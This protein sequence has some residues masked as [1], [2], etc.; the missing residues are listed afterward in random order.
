MS[1]KILDTHIHIWD[2]DKADYPWLANDSSL[3]HQTYRIETLEQERVAAGVTAGILVQAAGN[4][5]DTDLMLETAARKDWI[6]AVVAWLP[7]LDPLRAERVWK[8]KYSKNPYFKGVRHQIHDEP[9]PTWLLQ[10]P[11]IESLQ[12]LA[13][14]QLPYDL[15]GIRTEHIETAMG[16][17]T[18]V[19][20]LNMVFDHLNQPP[21]RTK[22]QFGR[23]GDLMK[24][25]AKHPGFY[26]KISGLGTTAGKDNW[27]EESLLPYLAFVLEH[28]GVDRC[29]CGGDWPVSLLA[30]S[31]TSTWEIYRKA[32]AQLVPDADAE[33]IL[34]SNA[35]RFYNLPL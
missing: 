12:W 18:K 24:E 7:L 19:P 23:W 35:C 26:V 29:C 20:E 9:D 34:Y 3:L 8:D 33:K 27:N 11:V 25:A 1:L 6:K 17:A 4:F 14:L 10:A 16:V 15:V 28:F 30:G 22:E 2:L 32:L 5:E 21:I 31:Y 13:S